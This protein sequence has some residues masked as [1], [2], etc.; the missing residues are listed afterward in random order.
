MPAKKLHK[1]LSSGNRPF[2]VRPQRADLGLTGRK[3]FMSLS[4]IVSGLGC[5]AM[6]ALGSE[7]ILPVGTAVGGLCDLV[8]V[9]SGMVFFG[10]AEGE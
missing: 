10:L 2:T 1:I 3:I 9:A 8:G 4:L 7:L 5:A 6:L